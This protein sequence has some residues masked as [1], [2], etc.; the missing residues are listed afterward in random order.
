MCDTSKMKPS[1]SKSC[2]ICLYPDWTEEI[3][4]SSEVETEII[5]DDYDALH[6][7]SDAGCRGCQI[8][9]EGWQHAVPNDGDRKSGSITFNRTSGNLYLHVFNKGH[10]YNVD[11]FTLADAPCFKHIR[12]ASL[13]PKRTDTKES[14]GMIQQ[15]LRACENEHKLCSDQDHRFPPYLLDIDSKLPDVIRLIEGQT[16]LRDTSYQPHYACLSHC[17]GK[18]RSRHITKHAN[19]ESNR[20]SILVSEL[21]RNFQDAVEIARALRIRYLWIDSLCIIQDDEEDWA[22]HVTHMAQ[23]Y[24][25][26]YITLAAGASADDEGGFFRESDIAFSDAHS[27]K[28]QGESGEYE[29]FFRKHLSHP[30]EG[31]PIGKALPLMTRGWVFQE[32]LL[33]RRFLCFAENEIWWECREDVACSC[34]TS[35]VRFN[36]RQLNKSGAKP[37]FPN[38]E[39]NKFDFSHLFTLPRAELFSLWRALV[40]QY[41]RR[42]LTFPRD[43]L[44]ALDGLRQ[45]FEKALLDQGGAGSYLWGSWT[46]ALKDD[47]LWSNLGYDAAGGRSRNAPS[48]SWTSAADGALEFPTELYDSQWAVKRTVNVEAA[49][50]ESQTETHKAVGLLLWGNLTEIKLQKHGE[51][52][53]MQEAYPGFR[54][55]LVCKYANPTQNTSPNSTVT[56]ALDERLVLQI[57][58]PSVKVEKEKDNHGDFFTDYKFWKDEKDLWSILNNMYFLDLGKERDLTPYGYIPSTFCWVAGLVLRDRNQVVSGHPTFERIGWLRFNSGKPAENWKPVGTYQDFVIF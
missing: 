16:I 26:A 45:A 39:P 21:P 52:D 1:K 57:A 11:I 3:L 30:D 40:S 53:G 46:E 9:S 14:L 49:T 17:W 2:S 55:C 6:A 27:I 10:V 43:K 50:D 22:Y 44:P 56:T 58:W 15:W 32:E 12:C 19:F 28:I 34:S 7:S 48:W 29:V 25:N 51:P 35:A 20:Q 36:Y 42:S 4:P 54:R 24:G 8:L 33:S 31:W 37:S 5:C 13:I 47:L 38:C 41:S 18:T 23:I